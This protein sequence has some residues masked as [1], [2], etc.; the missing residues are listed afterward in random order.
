MEM[1]AVSSSNI[2]AIGYDEEKKVLRIE[3]NSGRVY[4]YAEVPKRVYDGLLRA[5]SVGRYF[6]VHVKDQYSYSEA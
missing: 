1:Q 3:F 2:A 6:H 5:D 4:D